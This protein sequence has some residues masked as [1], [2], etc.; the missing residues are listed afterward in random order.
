MVHAAGIR[1]GVSVVTIDGEPCVDL[2][3]GCLAVL[4][5]V[6]GIPLAGEAVELGLIG[7]TLGAAHSALSGAQPGDAPR[8][9]WVDITAEHLAV[10]DW[11]RPAVRAAV[12]QWDALAGAITT[13]GLLH[14]DPAPE[15]F[16]W[17]APTRRCGLIDWSS[18]FYG[19]LLYDLASAVLYAGGAEQASALIAAYRTHGLLD[20]RQLAVGL[21]PM[22]RFRWAVQAD[23]FARRIASNDLTGLTEASENHKGLND[24][25][26]HLSAGLTSADTL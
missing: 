13:W 1:S 20:D 23:Y 7:D 24:A 16:L 17:S 8:F 21:D 2:R 25:R 15:A 26:V 18:A 12:E 19:P 6:D 14:G 3:D 9:H 5:W 22:L 10:A 4:A 11:V